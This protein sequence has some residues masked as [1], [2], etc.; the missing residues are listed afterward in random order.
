MFDAKILV[1]NFRGL[2]N[3]ETQ[4][5]LVQIVRQR[6]PNFIFLSETLAAPSLVTSVCAKLGFE[7][8]ICQPFSEESRGLAFMWHHGSRKEFRFTGI[9]G[10]THPRDRFRTWNLLRSLAAQSSLPW[11]VAWDFNEIFSNADKSGSPKRA[12]APMVRFR[13]ALVDCALVDMKFSGPQFTWANRFTK[14]RLDRACHTSSWR[15]RFPNSRVVTLPLSKSDHNPLLVV[16]KTSRALY[17][18]APKRFR[19]EEMWS[20][21]KDCGSVI[22]K[23]WMTP[24]TG[25][26][27]LQVGLKIHSTGWLLSSWEEGVFRQRHMEMKLLQAK[28]DQLMRLPYESCQWDEQ[29]ALQH[30]FNELLSLDETYWRQRSRV[31]WLKDGDRNTA[32]FHRRASNRK[33]RNCITGLF[34]LEGTWQTSPSAIATTLTNYY[35]NIFRHE[36]YDPFAADI[37]LNTVQ[38]RVTVEMNIRTVLE[39]GHLP[40]ES[41]YTHL[42][43]IHKVKEP[44]V[45]SDLRPIALCNVV[46]KI[47]S[48]VLANRLKVILPHIISPLQSAFVSG[49]L[50]SDKTLVVSE[51]NHF[52]KELRDQLDEFFSLKLDISKAY[53]KLE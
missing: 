12:A 7:G 20:Q 29:K 32:F 26:P 22:E 45:A 39:T 52:M 50:I 10:F 6:N 17:H 13:Q 21:H 11:L 19:F 33:S 9:Y 24:S 25:N 23:E 36:H 14:E 15:D 44:K 48:K 18:R 51:I 40:M 49:R 38:T 53:D 2:N 43:L 35:E 47:A 4:D 27:M 28:L 8:C 42:V 16:I 5:A 3:I 30:R 46:Y 31:L 37:V 41:N 1:W 34:D